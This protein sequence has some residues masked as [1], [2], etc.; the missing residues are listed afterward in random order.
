VLLVGHPGP[1]V[2][3]DLRAL[4][5]PLR[6]RRRGMVLPTAAAAALLE[7]DGIEWEPAARRAVEN[8]RD[9][10][11]AAPG[12]LAEAARIAA[13]GSAEA[14]RLV[15]DSRL[16][17]KL[18][19]HQAINLAILTTPG[20]WGGCV[21]D[22]Q[23]TGKTITMISVF[24]LLVERGE[25]DVLLVVCPK[26][27]AA[28]WTTEVQRF[29]G[30]LYRVVVAADGP[31][32]ERA[33]LLDAGAD[34]IVMNYETAAALKNSLRLVARRSR[35]VLA[36]DESFFVKNPSASRSSAVAEIR[37]WCTRAYALCGT[38][39][40][41]SP[42]DVV[43]QFNLIDFGF[44]FAAVTVT[45]DRDT[46][47]E[48]I[49]RAM[50]TRGLYVRNLKDTVLSG[51]PP[52]R[53]EDVVVPLSPQQQLAYDRER[54]DLVCDLRA[55]DDRTFGRKRASF[56]A[57]RSRL[58]RICSD[59]AGVLPGFSGIPAKD[60]ALDALL[61]DLVE[62]RGEKVVLWSFYRG[63]L[64]RL[65]RRYA[66][67]GLARIDGSVTDTAARRAAVR[68]FQD[69]DETMVFLGNP[70][71]AGAGL[72]LHRSRSVIFESLSNQAAHYLQSLD[73]VHRRGQARP[74][75]YIT[76]LARATLEEVEY[77]RL[78]QKA[79]AQAELL[80]DAI[81]PRITREILL[82]ELLGEQHAAETD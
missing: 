77:A 29:T 71:A 70:A 56:L 11:Q 51:L 25:A 10:R 74:V 68:S 66:R 17:D 36:V 33:A 3:P 82:G 2:T 52:R 42:A 47:A 32:A 39:A 80:G 1:G 73:R 26:S 79:I 78:Q 40:P 75:T 20:G 23:G 44:T 37:Q 30:D 8:V 48:P 18:D 43:A 81:A 63:S 14:H 60:Q 38:P 28:E 50:T 16:L 54:D 5:L 76:L 62:R 4:G 6:R 65:A 13:A 67:Y 12:V 24:D 31:R 46:D 35:M 22:E 9:V 45:G 27:M 69:D 21:F 15:A 41:N 34:V 61:A 64:D 7:L 19:E 72:T 49:R 59:P 53:F 58:L 55:I 57:R